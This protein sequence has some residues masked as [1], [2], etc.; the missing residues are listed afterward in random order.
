MTPAENFHPG[1]YLVDEMRWRGWH[2]GYLVAHGGG[3]P[4][5]GLAR[6]VFLSAQDRNCLL[7]IDSIELIARAFD[8]SAALFVNLQS[9]WLGNSAEPDKFD[10]PDDLFGP[11][12]FPAEHR[13]DNPASSEEPR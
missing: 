1:E 10:V 9:A 2:M 3:T 13:T 6:L 7:S 11:Y 12:T 4:E 5:D 8:V